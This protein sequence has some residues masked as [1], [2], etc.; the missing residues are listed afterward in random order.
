[1]ATKAPA[2]TPRRASDHGVS[3]KDYRPGDEYA[4]AGVKL[5]KRPAQINVFAADVVDPADVTY[6]TENTPDDVA[7]RARLL[8]ICISG[9]DQSQST[10]LGIPLQRFIPSPVCET[11]RNWDNVIKPFLQSYYPPSILELYKAC[12][13][14]Q[15]NFDL[16]RM[17]GVGEETLYDD[18]RYGF[19]AFL[20]EASTKEDS[21][22]PRTDWDASRPELVYKRVVSDFLIRTKLHTVPHYRTLEG[23]NVPVLS[24]LSSC[25]DIRR[26]P[27]LLPNGR[28]IWGF[29]IVNLTTVDV[30]VNGVPVKPGRL[31]G[32]LPNFA[33]F[34]WNNSAA[35]W[36]HSLS[37][38]DY[39]PDGILKAQPY[40]ARGEGHRVLDTYAGATYEH[41][42]AD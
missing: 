17:M 41:A 37:A 12:Q 23:S 33:V 10:L 39:A 38:R 8:R 18:R 11:A 32:P 2:P 4:F 34:Q 7:W 26:L 28:W 22:E 36:W 27:G 1:M 24:S 14:E 20:D 29:F 13:D 19:V 40:I 15:E 21:F 35:F 6:T 5:T 25:L 3:Y 42:H 9:T 16:H 30:I 31:A